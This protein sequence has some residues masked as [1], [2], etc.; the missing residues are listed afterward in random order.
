MLTFLKENAD[1][2]VKLAVN[3]IAMTIFG[4]LLSAATVT[5]KTLLLVTGILSIL[6]YMYLLYTSAW[7]IGAHDK[8]RIDGG[9]LKRMPLKGLYLSLA[10]N[11]VN[12]LL[13][14]I[15]IICYYLGVQFGFEW[16]AGTMAVCYN[17]SW[18][19]NGMYNAVLSFI[20]V[21][22]LKFWLMLAAVIPA[23]VFTELAYLAG[24]NN[25][26]IFGFLGLNGKQ[27]R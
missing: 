1:N 8:I 7:D 18:L 22:Q 11:S 17:I 6:F 9:R 13:A 19:L 21:G 23:L 5:N 25:Y 20:S 4:L 24:S 2:I 16:A 3:Q 12:I 14:L 10:A 15:A 26:R 27:R